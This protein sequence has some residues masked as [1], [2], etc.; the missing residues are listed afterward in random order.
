LQG[1]RAVYAHFAKAQKY[2]QGKIDLQFFDIS[3]NNVVE[4]HGKI[5]EILH[6]C[7]FVG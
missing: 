7:S 5:I 1:S 6:G 4:D 3:T 2:E